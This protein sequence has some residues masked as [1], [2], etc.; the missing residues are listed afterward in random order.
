MFNTT[1]AEIT[2][3]LANAKA[4]KNEVRFLDIVNAALI[5]FDVIEEFSEVDSRSHVYVVSGFVPQFDEPEEVEP[6]SL[7]KLVD[8]SFILSLDNGDEYLLIKGL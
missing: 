8:G 2:E 7:I 3:I 1:K 6:I 5:T 4:L